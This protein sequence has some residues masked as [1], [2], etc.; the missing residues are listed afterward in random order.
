[1]F[2]KVTIPK[3]SKRSCEEI[4]KMKSSWTEEKRK[5]YSKMFSGK[6]NPMYGKNLQMKLK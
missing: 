1:M 4:E 3:G 2:G 6:N 5:K